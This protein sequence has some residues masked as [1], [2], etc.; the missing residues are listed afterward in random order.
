M[1]WRRWNVLTV[2]LLAIAST[3][4][5]LWNY[6]LDP[7]GVF[8]T[9]L[10]SR[11]SY[12]IN[13][14]Y[15]KLDYLL[16]TH[17]PD[18]FILG[19]SAMDI[20]DPRKANS[21]CQGASWYNLSVLSGNAGDALQMLRALKQRGKK[22][23]R[24]LYGV[25]VLAFVESPG[26]DGGFLRY[27]PAIDGSSYYRFFADYLFAPSFMEGEGHIEHALRSAPVI[28]YDIDTTGM[29]RLPGPDREIHD[30]PRAYHVHKF[31][32]SRSVRTDI[33][34]VTARWEELVQLRDWA[35]ANNVTAYW[36][37]PPIHHDIR[38]GMTSRSWDTFHKRVRQI[39]GDIPDWSVKRSI[40]ERDESM[41]YDPRHFRPTV[42]TAML[43]DV[44]ANCR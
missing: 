43:A 33:D 31:A 1:T 17:S 34:F 27:H 44:L 41:Y 22:I 26:H 18:S 28:A 30:D 39:L 23:R 8:Q 16:S 42:G 3:I 38:D 11:D 9:H 24:F 10:L 15:R 25:D 14:R 32:P 19:N 13:E 6:V 12:N 29:L 40:T 36:V 5:P 2:S 4:V 7:F 21:L 35:K 37:I 20:I